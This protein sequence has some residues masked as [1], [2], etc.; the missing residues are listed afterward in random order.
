MLPVA[1]HALPIILASGDL[2]HAHAPCQ[3]MTPCRM[4]ASRASTSAAVGQRI[5]MS[6]GQS[7]ARDISQD[8]RPRK[9]KH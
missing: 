4:A 2:S 9:A 6:G 8:C 1:M 5:P 7:S 3:V